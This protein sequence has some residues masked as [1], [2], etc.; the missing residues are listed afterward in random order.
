MHYGIFSGI[1]GHKMRGPQGVVVFPDLDALEAMLVSRAQKQQEQ[2]GPK[3]GPAPTPATVTEPGAQPVQQHSA[4]HPLVSAAKAADLEG[5]LLPV[6]QALNMERCAWLCVCV[7]ARARV[8]ACLDVA[9]VGYPRAQHIWECAMCMCVCV[10][11][12]LFVHLECVHLCMWLHT[13][14]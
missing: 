5:L 9:A 6:V 11:V 2:G 13:T 12:L 7:C 4:E 3:G 8:R 10:C 1:N 14:C